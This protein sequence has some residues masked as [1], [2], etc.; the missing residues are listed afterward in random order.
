LL[1]RSQPAGCSAKAGARGKHATEG[2][3][4]SFQAAL[5]VSLF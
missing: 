5:D 3:L 4:D 2:R 1:R